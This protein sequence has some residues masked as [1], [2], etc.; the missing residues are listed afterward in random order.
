MSISTDLIMVGLVLADLMLLA[1]SRMLSLAR[2]VALQGCL[3]GLFPFVMNTDGLSARAVAMCIVTF[4]IK[5]LAFPWMVIHTLRRVGVNRE[6]QPFIGY[7]SSI[8]VGCLA[9]GVSLW[10]STRMNL[11]LDDHISSLVVPVAF[12]TMFVGLLLVVSRHKALAQ[13]VGYL[14]F[15]NGIYLFGI[16][17]VGEIPFLVEF[18]VLLDAFVALFVMGIAIYQIGHEFDHIDTDRLDSLKG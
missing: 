8:L 13:A 11:P 5:G 12:L 1:S 2:G 6:V 3:L 16:S 4:A 10:L 7:T 14:V 9:F 18:G 15:E 17:F